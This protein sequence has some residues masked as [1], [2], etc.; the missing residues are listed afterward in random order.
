MNEKIEL[1]F[2]IALRSI[3]RQDPD[4]ILIGEIR[5]VE[6][7]QIA[8]QAALTGHL[9]LSTLHTNDAP[10]AI[11]RLLDMHIEPFLI[12]STVINV[13]AQRL[14]RTLCPSCKKEHKPTEDQLSRLGLSA[15]EAGKITFFEA[16]GCD[17]CL[18]TGYK[19]RLAIF[20]MMEIDDEIRKLIVERT[21][22]SAIRRKAIENGM[23]VLVEDGIRR[24]KEGITTI[25][26]VLAAAHLEDLEG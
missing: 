12:A 10:T 25:D 24:L 21:E 2:A 26:E 7:A 4:I 23:T 15:E 14:V 20:E 9:V 6:T 11:T 22:V 1:T 5:D 17:D 16:G 8:T 13:I 3:L 19:G 18:K